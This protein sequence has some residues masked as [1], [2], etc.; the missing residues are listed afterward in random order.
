[1]GN[2]EINDVELKHKRWGVENGNIEEIWNN[3]K[4]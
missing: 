3:V 1:M 2:G 4:M